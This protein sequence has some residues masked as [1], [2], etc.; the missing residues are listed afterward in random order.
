MSILSLKALEIAKTQ[1]GKHE[2]PRGSNWGPDIKKYLASVGITKPS[3]WCASFAY[4]CFDEA[5]RELGMKNPLT[6]VGGVLRQWEFSPKYRIPKNLIPQPGDLFVLDH[7]KGLGHMGI[8]E[9][10]DPQ[11]FEEYAIEGN[12]NSDGSRDGEEV[13]RHKRLPTDPKLVGFLRF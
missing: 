13:V 4:W 6:K 12:S 2:I 9:S 8:I 3:A 10:V 11:T 5:S 7:G 1:L